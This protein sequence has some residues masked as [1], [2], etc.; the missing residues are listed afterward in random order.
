MKDNYTLQLTN[1]QA[2]GLSVALALVTQ[3]LNVKPGAPVY[4]TI[5]L[6]EGGIT[7]TLIKTEMELLQEAI[8][9]QLTEQDAS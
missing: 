6:E 2:R 7:G 3:L 1:H 4:P 5:M 8:L 9:Q